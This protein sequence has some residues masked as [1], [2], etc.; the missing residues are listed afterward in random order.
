MDLLDMLG[1]GGEPTRTERTR[2]GGVC[3]CV[4]VCVR[5]CVCVWY[6]RVTSHTV[7]EDVGVVDWLFGPPAPR[8]A[9]GMYVCVVFCP[10]QLRGSYAYG[11][12]RNSML[13]ALVTAFC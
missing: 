12:V 7:A 2:T 13:W 10:Y 6:E 4:C 8:A 5:V 1:F 3:V 9:A 11:C